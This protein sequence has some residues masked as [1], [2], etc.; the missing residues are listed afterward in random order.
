MS[1]GERDARYASILQPLLTDL[2][3]RVGSRE[4]TAES[5]DNAFPQAT[6]LIKRAAEKLPRARF[7]RHLKPF[8]NAE[9]VRLKR[10]KVAAYRA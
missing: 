10:E 6:V 7:C 3:F 1:A 9:L 8:W 5:I 4:A 2:T